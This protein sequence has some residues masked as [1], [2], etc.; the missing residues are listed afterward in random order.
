MALLTVVKYINKQLIY[1][2]W[3]F[4]EVFGTVTRKENLF[5]SDTL[6]QNLY[7]VVLIVVLLRQEISDRA[8]SRIDSRAAGRPQAGTILSSSVQ[9]RLGSVASRN[10]VNARR[11]APGGF[12]TQRICSLQFCEARR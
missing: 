2:N 3:R 5:G 12:L 7:D 8:Q 4:V 6:K 10:R 1:I 9:S 11:L